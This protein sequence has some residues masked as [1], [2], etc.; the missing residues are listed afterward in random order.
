MKRK[1]KKGQRVFSL[2]LRRPGMIVGR[3]LGEPRQY[4]VQSIDEFGHGLEADDWVYDLIP[5]T[6]HRDAK[7]NRN[8]ARRLERI[9][10]KLEQ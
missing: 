5:L 6:R 1:Y 2:T 10:R 3:V 8:L 4:T 7:R 9:I